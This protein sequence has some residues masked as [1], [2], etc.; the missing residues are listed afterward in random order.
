LATAAKTPKAARIRDRGDESATTI[1]PTD[2][3][4]SEKTNENARLDSSEASGC[5]SAD[6]LLSIILLDRSIFR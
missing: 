3:G 2:L 6:A 4:I 5:Q 1:A